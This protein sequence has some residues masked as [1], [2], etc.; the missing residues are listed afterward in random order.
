MEA[1]FNDIQ[2]L[3]SSKDLLGIFAR[4]ADDPLGATDFVFRQVASDC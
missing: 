2:P 1:M 3:F 4:V